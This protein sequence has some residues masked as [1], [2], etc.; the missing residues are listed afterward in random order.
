MFYLLF[1]LDDRTIRS[2]SG[3]PKN[4]WILRIRRIQRPH[5]Q[6]RIQGATRP[7][8]GILNELIF[9]YLISISWKVVF[10]E[11]LNRQENIAY[12]LYFLCSLGI[13]NPVIFTEL[14]RIRYL[15]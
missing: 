11:S 9:T 1:L 10:S 12:R 2:G 5:S 6:I 14:V 8:V 7:D 13:I 15:P 3:R 4:I